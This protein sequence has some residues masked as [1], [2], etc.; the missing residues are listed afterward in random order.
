[1]LAKWETVRI[2]GTFRRLSTPSLSNLSSI[3]VTASLF[4]SFSFHPFQVNVFICSIVKTDS[5]R[6]PISKNRSAHT[7]DNPQYKPCMISY[8]LYRRFWQIFIISASSSSKHRRHVRSY[9]S[10]IQYLYHM[11]IH[12]I[13]AY[14]LRDVCTLKSVFVRSFLLP[15]LY[16]RIF[17]SYDV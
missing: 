5:S 12:L 4:L 10:P 14:S 17:L 11:S 8:R 16:V 2:I 15:F 7:H 6:F 1:M 13:I 9:L 3:I